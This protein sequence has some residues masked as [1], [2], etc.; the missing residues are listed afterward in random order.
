MLR[1]NTALPSTPKGAQNSL[2]AAARFVNGALTLNDAG[3]GPAGF[4]SGRRP[5]DD[6]VDITLRV[7]MGYLLLPGANKPASASLQYTKGKLVADSRFDNA[8]PNLRAPLPGSPNGQ[9]GKD[10]NPGESA[11]PESGDKD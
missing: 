11:G 5:G 1:L 8:F 4:P 9:N 6:V 10:E 3:C 7:A 2:G